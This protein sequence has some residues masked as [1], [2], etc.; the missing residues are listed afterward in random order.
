MLVQMEEVT[1]RATM[2]LFVME[3]YGVSPQ[4]ILWPIYHYLLV[5]CMQG[6]FKDHQI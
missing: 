6:P 5:G 2:A 4:Q 3:P 1:S